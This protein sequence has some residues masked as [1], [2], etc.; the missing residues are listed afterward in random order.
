M[1]PGGRIRSRSPNRASVSSVRPAMRPAPICPRSLG[2][3]GE[4][5]SCM[6][7]AAR[8]A[9]EPARGAR[10]GPPHCVVSSPKA[11]SRRDGRHSRRSLSCSA[12]RSSPLSTGHSGSGLASHRWNG[13]GGW[14]S[15]RAP[16]RRSTAHARVETA[17]TSLPGEGAPRSHVSLQRGRQKAR[18]SVA[19][20]PRRPELATPRAVRRPSG[21]APRATVPSH[22]GWP[23]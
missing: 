9:R 12:T 5:P 1:L 22:R 3:A 11:F 20:P 2:T 18:A 17:S 4:T 23:R 15:R 7:L 10:R 13:G 6:R 21:R 16:R 8:I 14:R 19:L